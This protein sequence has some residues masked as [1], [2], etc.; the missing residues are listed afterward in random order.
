MHR[1][2]ITLIVASAVAVVGLTAPAR[3]GSDDL[4]KFLAGFTALVIIGSAIEDARKRDD[5]NVTRNPY[6]HNTYGNTYGNTRGNTYGHTRHQPVHPKPL[7]PRV[8][9]FDL[10]G[11]CMRTYK[12]N[13]KNVNLLGRGCLKERYRHTQ[14]LPYACQFQFRTREGTRT[15]Y[16]PVCLRERGYRISRR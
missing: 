8:A 9:R 14:S 12:I 7:P 6:P 10:P 3:A 13:R 5:V 11:E 1:K 2:F 15:G 16:E 4:A